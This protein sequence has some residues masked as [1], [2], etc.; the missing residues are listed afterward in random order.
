MLQ[1]RRHVAYMATTGKAANKLKEVTDRPV[2]TVHSRLFKG[3]SQ[4]EDGGVAFY[5]PVEICLPGEV[6]ICDEASMVDS[7]LGRTI[8][9][10]LPPGSTLVY[11]GD[12]EQLPPVSGRGWGPDFDNPDAVLTEIHRQASGNPILEISATIR[13]GGRLPEDSVEPWFVRRDG[14]LSDVAEWAVGH[15]QQGTDVAVICYT[16]KSVSGLNLLIRNMLGYRGIG[17][18]V[19]GEKLLC[20]HN[21]KRLG[22]MNGESMRVVGIEHDFGQ[23][24]NERYPPG[25]RIRQHA[26]GWHGAISE[27][28][29]KAMCLKVSGTGVRDGYVWVHPE[30]IGQPYHPDFSGFTKSLRGIDKRAML[31]VDYGYAIT[32]HRSQGSQW[33]LVGIV[34]DDTMQWRGQQSVANAIM[35]RRML[36]TGITRTRESAWV[37]DTRRRR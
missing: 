31:H 7:D 22:R 2:S 37:W 3:V 17:P 8:E 36:Y 5:N 15:I 33:P 19:V 18:I 35:M 27:F 34:L 21:N 26:D 14:N 1:A 25:T 29:R 6:I 10:N 4:M 28:Q 20:R 30:L 24:W 11:V 12:R 32:Y 16:N 13:K 9:Q 23:W